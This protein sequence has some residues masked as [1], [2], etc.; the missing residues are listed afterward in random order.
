MTDFDEIA[1]KKIS[2]KSLFKICSL[3]I[4]GFFL[5]GFFFGFLSLFG[6]RT[7]SWNHVAVFGVSGLLIGILIGLVIGVALCLINFVVVF[8][9]MNILCRFKD[10]KF[11]YEK[12]D[13]EI[14]LNV[15]DKRSSP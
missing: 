12:P 13:T 4:I 11:Q 1:I 5:V 14:I 8:V 9:G 15:E 10:S 3:G 2:A 7:V 6:L